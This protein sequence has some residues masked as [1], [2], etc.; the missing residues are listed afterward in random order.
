MDELRTPMVAA[1]TTDPETNACSVSRPGTPVSARE[2]LCLSLILAVGAWLRF[3]RLDLIEFK[4]DEAIAAYLALQF[5]KGGS[6][7]LAGL[8]SSVG[9]TNPPMFIYMLMP[10][11]LVS[12]DPAVVG[13]L[14]AAQSL[15]AVLV[16]WH[17]G[18]KY[19]SPLTGLVAAA[20]FAV[21]PW[22]VIYSRKIWSIDFEPLLTALAI[23]ALHVVVI[24]RRPKAIFW[25]LLLCSCLVMNHF[26]GLGPMA[27]VLGILL[28]LRPKFDWRYAAGGVAVALVFLLPYLR[29]Q[30][31]R[32][33]ADFRQAMQTVGGQKWQIPSGITVHPETGARLPRR[34]HWVHALSIMNAGSMEDVL[35]LGAESRHDSL[36]IYAQKPGGPHRYF[37]ETLTLGDWLLRLQQL[38][39]VAGLV[40]LVILAARGVCWSKRFPFFHV[41]TESGAQTGWIL[42]LWVVTPLIM[43]WIGRLWTYMLYFVILY[44]VPFLATAIILQK[45]A[46][47]TKQCFARGAIFVAVG[48]MVLWNIVFM[49]D[50][51]RYLDREGGAF[52]TYGTVLGYRQQLAHFVAERGGQRVFDESAAE[53]NFMVAKSLGKMPAAPKELQQPL[54][55]QMDAL[56][57]VELVQ[58]DFAYLVLLEKNKASMTQSFP[59]NLILVVVDENRARLEPQQWQQLAAMPQTNFGPLR[60]LFVKRQE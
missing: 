59:T 7:P 46:A 1:R 36:R 3:M 52:G 10:L 20:L 15:L 19:Y 13:C 11:V 6:L 12:G 23:W 56:G 50:F 48:A 32:D 5:V 25:V 58:A 29:F 35:G 54:L 2:W 45:L 17:V 53:L 22:A 44:P 28:V 33:W 42:V 41:S 31:M 14:I 9:V 51:Y 24:D 16:C 38:L 37:N 34:E 18:R 57:R 40:Y 21:S 47:K 39:F 43:F 26:S 49:M 8:M 27:A 60:L 30:G 4:S 55:A